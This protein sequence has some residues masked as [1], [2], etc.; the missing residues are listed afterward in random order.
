MTN[1]LLL[2]AF[3]FTAFNTGLIWTIQLVHYPGFL[4][5]DIAQHKDYHH[6]HVKAITPLVAFSMLGELV[7]SIWLI[8]RVGAEAP[9]LVGSGAV[10][11]M[12]I[13]IHTAA[14]AVPLHNR[15]SRNYS[16]RTTQQLIRA[17]WCRTI[18]WS[19]KTM[20]YGFLM[21]SLLP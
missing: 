4:R 16:I 17:N 1:L 20:I 5:I 21:L 19:L 10:L 2:L 14:I 9:Y 3:A 7:C 13:W 12:A 11:I 18:L 8:F 15:L 6:F